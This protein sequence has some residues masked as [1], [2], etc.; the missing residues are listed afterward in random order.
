VV[1]SFPRTR[2][3]LKPHMITPAKPHKRTKEPNGPLWI[4]S[5][6]ITNAIMPG[7]KHTHQIIP[8][9]ENAHLQQ[10]F[11]PLRFLI[12]GLSM[13]FLHCLARTKEHQEVERHQ[14]VFR[15]QRTVL[16]TLKYMIICVHQG[17]RCQSGGGPSCPLGIPSRPLLLMC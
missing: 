16:C 11:V 2:L 1:H 15:K 6:V 13:I 4:V 9:H 14:S 3:V 17:A 5:L 10:L 12:I 7:R 8:F